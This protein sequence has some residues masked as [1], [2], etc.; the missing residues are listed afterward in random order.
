MP[1]LPKI[2]V[3]TGAGISAESGIRT[4]RS[5]DG[6]WEEHHIEDVATPEGYARN[7]QLVREFYNGLRHK[8]FDPKIQPNAAHLALAKLDEKFGDNLLIVTQNIDNLHERAGSKNVIHMHGSLLELRCEHSGKVYA[9]EKEWTAQ[10]KCTCCHT[11]QPLRP[12]I[13]WFNEMPLAMDRIDE[14]IRDCLYFISIGTSGNVY[15]AAGFVQEAN[16]NGAKTIELNLEPSKGRA[17][18]RIGH[19]GPATE[20]VPKFVEEM[21]FLYC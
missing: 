18:F 5:E 1:K 11:P 10:D 21:L 13:V 6:L 15:P 14:E 20:V 4:F 17:A 16:F 19:Y 2:V 3:L 7:P 9:W 12:N 8:L